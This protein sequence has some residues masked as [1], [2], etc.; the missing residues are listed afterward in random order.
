MSST[1][2]IGVLAVQG[3]FAEHA[4]M[5]E[6]LGAKPFL[7]RQKADLNRTMD[8]LILPGG[9]STVQGKLLHELGL[10]EPLKSRIEQGMPVF[11]TCAGMILLAKQLEQDETVHF[12]VMDIV[13]RRNAYGRQLGSF[14]AHEDFADC[15]KI[16]MPFIRAPYIAQTGTQ[17]EALAVVDGKTVAARQNNMLA[18]SFHPEVTQETAVHRYFLR[19]VEESKKR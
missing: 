9:E 1:L 10:F 7:I 19:M 3:A 8:A 15:G 18:I 13:V 14:V 12:G 2:E 16:E 5:M 11:G 17:A 6:T 4:A